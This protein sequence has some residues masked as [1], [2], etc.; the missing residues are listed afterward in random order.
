VKNAVDVLG[1]VANGP[2][3]LSG[4]TH[5]CNT[6]TVGRVR[7]IS[8]SVYLGLACFHRV[9]LGFHEIW[10]A[11]ASQAL[12]MCLRTLAA[13]PFIAWQQTKTSKIGTT[14]QTLRRLGL[15]LEEAEF[16]FVILSTACAFLD[17]HFTHNFY[18]AVS[19]NLVK[20]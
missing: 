2:Q 11:E 19:H 17:V 1:W 20:T 16:L 8:D 4:V 5:T 10:Q 14:R 18:M 15:S 13:D 3:Q 12:A 7:V 6:T 9:L